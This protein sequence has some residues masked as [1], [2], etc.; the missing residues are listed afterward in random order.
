MACYT[1]CATIGNLTMVTFFVKRFGEVR[2]A[3]VGAI[4]GGASLVM[5]GFSTKSWMVGIGV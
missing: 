1:T 5:L 3:A 4:S 2:L